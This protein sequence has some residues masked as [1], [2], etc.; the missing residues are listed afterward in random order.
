MRIPYS[1]TKF[2]IRLQEDVEMS[3]SYNRAYIYL[4]THPSPSPA[5]FTF[6]CSLAGFTLPSGPQFMPMQA[7]PGSFPGSTFQ[8]HQPFVPQPTGG[9]NSF[10]PPPLEPQPTGVSTVSMPQAPT[11]STAPLVPQQTGPAPPVRFGVKSDAPR[12]AP[13]PT[14]RRANLAQASEYRLN[15][16]LTLPGSL[17]SLGRVC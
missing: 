8:P 7:Q 12:L 6:P 9:V 10:L 3:S 5:P 2:R 11:L 14:G 4:S 1:W 15:S 17:F 13:Q 16:L